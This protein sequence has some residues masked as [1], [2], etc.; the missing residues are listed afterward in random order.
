MFANSA[1][2]DIDVCNR[3]NSCNT[4]IT[5]SQQCSEQSVI[6]VSVSLYK[7]RTSER[8]GEWVSGLCRSRPTSSPT[9][10]VVSGITCGRYSSL[11][12]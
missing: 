3:L 8:A 11:G 10:F 4:P 7:D 12:M 9:F 1:F 5:E 2:I 6:N